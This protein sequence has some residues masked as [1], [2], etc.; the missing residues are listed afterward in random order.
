MSDQ[1]FDDRVSAGVARVLESL[2]NLLSRVGIL[3]EPT[4]D[5]GPKGIQL[6]GPGAPLAGLIFFSAHPLGDGAFV[7][8]QQVRDLS[9]GKR[10]AVAQLTDLLEGLVIDHA[11]PPITFLRRSATD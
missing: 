5:V 4:H 10:V 2:K 1:H 11:A 9:G 8:T 6:A 7:Q 3:I